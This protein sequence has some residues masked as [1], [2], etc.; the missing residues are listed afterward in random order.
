M[1]S[2]P[3]ITWLITLWVVLAAC[4]KGESE[5]RPASE[6]VAP[7]PAAT[8][9]PASAQTQ[10]AAEPAQETPP[11]TE[12][13][14]QVAETDDGVEQEPNPDAKNAPILKLAQLAPRAPATAKYKEG[15]HYQRL[16][17]TQPVDVSPDQVQVTESFWYGCPHCYALEPQV[18]KWLASGKP[19][20]VVFTRMPGAWDEVK[21]R[22]GRLFFAAESLGKLEELHPHIFR[23][24]H[25]KNNALLTVDQ[26]RAFFNAHGVDDAAF[27]KHYGALSIERK[28]D[29]AHLLM[30]RYRIS[31]VPAFVVNGKYTLDVS[32]AGGEQ[33]VFELI[34]ELAARERAKE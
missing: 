14:E 7:A 34:N 4:G 8:A 17:P 26:V 31:G 27:Q 3:R 15:V 22:H 20:Y 6:A 24:I 21:R 13:V 11:A 25:D 18:E 30:Q 33:Q 12:V 16:S 29:Q 10:S 9:A 19:D 23:E 28:L 1:K 32:S 2:S 5:A